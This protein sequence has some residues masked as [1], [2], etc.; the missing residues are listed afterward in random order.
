MIPTSS[1]PTLSHVEIFWP[2]HLP[3][4]RDSTMKFFRLSNCE[5]LLWIGQVWCPA[6]SYYLMNSQFPTSVII[7]W[8]K[9]KCTKVQTI[10]IYL[11]LFWRIHTEFFHK[12]EKSNILAKSKY[13]FFIFEEVYFFW[14]KIVGLAV[15]DIDASL[16]RKGSFIRY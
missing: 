7:I 13:A 6:F 9:Y 16:Y 11:F 1:T 3:S 14:W 12:Y 2:N 5:H 15:V 4:L 10:H 8:N